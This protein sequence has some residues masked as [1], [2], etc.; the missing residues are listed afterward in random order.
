MV[1]AGRPPQ[2]Y[3]TMAQ[4]QLE[5]A[6][7]LRKAF[8]TFDVDKNGSLS[9]CELR[10][11]LTRPGTGAALSEDDAAKLL[12]EFDTDGNGMLSLD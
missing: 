10:A 5:V 9:A 4:A 2:G 12:A 7:R 6:A 3:S 11:V 8:D 1:W